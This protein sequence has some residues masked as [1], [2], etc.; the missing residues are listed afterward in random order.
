M[1]VLKRMSSPMSIYLYVFIIRQSKI[2]E[3]PS[4]IEHGHGHKTSLNVKM[5]QVRLWEG[6][7]W[8][9][10]SWLVW[11]PKPKVEHGQFQLLVFLF[12]KLH[13]QPEYKPLNPTYIIRF[14]I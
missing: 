8:T 2:R 4:N 1:R 14:Y 7:K 3:Y 10:P 5:F 9:P 12:I 13:N 6:I 11:K